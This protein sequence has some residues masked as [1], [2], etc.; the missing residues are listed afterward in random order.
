[1]LVSV[2]VPC[3]NSQNTIKNLVELTIKEFKKMPEYT[4]EFVLVNDYSKDQTFLYIKELAE[5]YSFVKGIKLARQFGQHNALMAAMNYAEGDLIVGMDDD[6]QTHPS[7]LHI[8]LDKIKEGYDL[9]YGNYEK[10]KNSFLKNLS[11]KFNAVTS[12]ILL[13]RPKEIVSSNYWVITRYAVSYTHLRVS[14]YFLLSPLLSVFYLTLSCFSGR[15]N[16]Y[17]VYKS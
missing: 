7:Q 6:L 14:R 9:V 8:L 1:M 17:S 11:S 3:Y 10:R 16:S 2:V 13:G 15:K 4:Y 5:K 12:R